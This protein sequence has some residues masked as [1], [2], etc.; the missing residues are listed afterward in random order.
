MTKYCKYCGTRISFG[1]WLFG[2]D[3]VFCSNEIE[4]QRCEEQK[5][6]S[7]RYWDEQKK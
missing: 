1:E 3:C 2:R 5:K 7:K 6:D 4:R